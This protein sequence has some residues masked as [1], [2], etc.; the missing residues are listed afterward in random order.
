MSLQP[1]GTPSPSDVLA[2]S[3]KEIPKSVKT[4][5]LASLVIGAIIFLIGV[6]V[7]PEEAWSAFHAELAVLHRVVGG[8]VHVRR[9][10]AHHHG[11]VVAV[12]DPVHGGLRRVPARGVHLPGADVPR[13]PSLRVPVGAR[14]GA[15]SRR[16]RSTSIRRSWSFAIW[17]SSRSSARSRSGSSTS[18]CGWMSAACRS[19]ARS[20]RRAGALACGRALARSAARFTRRTRFRASS[21]SSR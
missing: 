3:S 14:R 21:P 5:L 13:G 17:P 9:R 6:F 4:A 10:A 16:R 7:T 11:A 1:V 8:R 19:G 12:G 2:A 15:E 18:R 20:G